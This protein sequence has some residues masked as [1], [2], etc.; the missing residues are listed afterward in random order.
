VISTSLD[1]RPFIGIPYKDKGIG[2]DGVDCLG[3]CVLFNRHALNKEI[4]THH[5][6][7]SSADDFDE[8][9]LGFAEGKKRWTKTDHDPQIGDVILFRQMGIVSHAGVYLDGVDFLHSV[10]GQASCLVRMD[11]FNWAKRIDGIMRWN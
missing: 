3:L 2:F 7:Y 4:P 10:H 11:D 8:T 6:Y 1:L 9:A 5:E